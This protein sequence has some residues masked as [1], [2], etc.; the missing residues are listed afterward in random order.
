MEN[1]EVAFL[2][3]MTAGMTHE[4]KNVLAIVKE[5]SGLMQDLLCLGQGKS[6]PDIEKFKRVVSTIQRQVERG[7]DLL[8]LLNRLAHS[9]DS[10]D[11]VTGMNDLVLNSANLMQRF[12][13]LRQVGL[14]AHP[15]DPDFMM[16]TDPFQALMVCTSCIE[17]CLKR[18]PP[19]SRI[20]FEARGA[21]GEV[22]FDLVMESTAEP[23]TAGEGSTA[24][25][26]LS[27]ELTDLEP[28]I[29]RLEA[30]LDFQ[31]SGGILSGLSITFPLKRGR[32]EIGS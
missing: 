18:L 6:M 5:A 3:R 11:A 17:Y 28:F 2:G 31:E 10:R 13:R 23:E 27:S 9:M 4:I 12:A 24:D 8:I 22:R 16:Q 20:V 30:R 15:A 32:P 26:A 14:D 19:E 1:Q 7:D 29:R 21:A 25:H